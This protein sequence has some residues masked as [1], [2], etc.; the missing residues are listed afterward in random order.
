[1]MNS[2]KK[3]VVLTS[4]IATCAF[5][6]PISAASDLKNKSSTLEL[7]VS[8]DGS[9]DVRLFLTSGGN[10]QIMNIPAGD[11]YTL[12]FSVTRTYDITVAGGPDK[13]SYENLTLPPN[14][15]FLTIGST[16]CKLT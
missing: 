12:T 10:S 11:R 4:L 6:T 5:V 14:E 7:K 15:R 13:C 9:K 8:N 16:E 2:F 3:A 1:M